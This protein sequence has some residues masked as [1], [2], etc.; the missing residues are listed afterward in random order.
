MYFTA[1]FILLAI[2][3]KRHEI[4][5]R[6]L[7]IYTILAGFL[8]WNFIAIETEEPIWFWSITWT[9]YVIF[10][11]VL[12]FTLYG[13]RTREANIIYNVK[14]FINNIKNLKFTQQVI[15]I[16][17][18][19]IINWIFIFVL[20]SLRLVA[21]SEALLVSILLNAFCYFWYYTSQKKKYGESRPWSNVI[22][23]YISL[24]IGVLGL[25]FFQISVTDKNLQPELS[26]QQNLPCTI[27]NFYDWHDLWHFCTSYCLGIFFLSL[28]LIDEDII[29]KRKDVIIAF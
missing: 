5:K 21:F 29:D 12:I 7:L 17:T 6:P 16:L 14:T 27:L 11:L 23:N 2:F 1:S 25:F 10:T 28:Q 22:L 4:N 9:L 8:S 15:A 19:T 18:V 24:L 13:E 3:Y 26:R 20:G